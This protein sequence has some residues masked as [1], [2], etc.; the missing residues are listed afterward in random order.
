MGKY[1][2]KTFLEDV[3]NR[4]KDLRGDKANTTYLVSEIDW[5]P[6]CGY[7]KVRSYA[8]SKGSD[9]LMKEIKKDDDRELIN[10]QAFDIP[11]YVKNQVGDHWVQNYIHE[12][13]LKPTN[14]YYANGRLGV[15]FNDDVPTW[16]NK[17][18][19]SEIKFFSEKEVLLL[20]M[21]M[22]VRTTDSKAKYVALNKAEGDFEIK[23]QQIDFLKRTNLDAFLEEKPLFSNKELSF[24]MS[25]EGLYL[26][27][28]YLEKSRL[29]SALFPDINEYKEYI[30]SNGLEKIILDSLG[31][32]DSTTAAEIK[33][34]FYGYRP[35]SALDDWNDKKLTDQEILLKKESFKE[36]NPAHEKIKSEIKLGILDKLQKHLQDDMMKLGGY[37]LGSVFEKSENEIFNHIK[38]HINFSM[39]TNNSF[40][41]KSLKQY[42]DICFNVKKAT[43]SFQFKKNDI[44]EVIKVVES[45]NEIISSLENIEKAPP[46]L[47]NLMSYAILAEMSNQAEYQDLSQFFEKLG[48]DTKQLSK[49]LDISYITDENDPKVHDIESF[50]AD[51]YRLVN[52]DYSLSV[53]NNSDEFQLRNLK[54]GN[55]EVIDK[56]IHLGDLKQFESKFSGF[57]TKRDLFIAAGASGYIMTDEHITK[58]LVF[59][60]NLLSMAKNKELEGGKEFS[61]SLYAGLLAL[62]SEAYNNIKVTCLDGLIGK[63][64]I[65]ID[66]DQKRG[67]LIDAIEFQI[68]KR[69][70]QIEGHLSE[71]AYYSVVHSIDQGMAEDIT[72]EV[73]KMSMAYFS[74]YRFMV[75][76]DPAGADNDYGQVVGCDYYIN[77]R[78]KNP[79]E[80]FEPNLLTTQEWHGIVAKDTRLLEFIP[81]E[82]IQKE[83]FWNNYQDLVG[84][85]SYLNHP[86]NDWLQGGFDKYEVF[87]KM[88]KSLLNN[89]VVYSDLV[90][91]GVAEPRQ[92]QKVTEA[93][94]VPDTIKGVQ[95]S[96]EQ[97][98]RLSQGKGVFIKGMKSDRD[99]KLFSGVAKIN[100]E[101]GE[102][103]FTPPMHK[104]KEVQGEKAQQRDER[105]PNQS[106]PTIVVA[107]P[108]AVKAKGR[109]M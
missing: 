61:P 57:H 83:D 24:K 56:R 70:Q 64:E 8:Y 14:S 28:A 48:I 36:I 55:L 76:Y 6:D 73:A 38:N 22:D 77:D 72:P 10:V 1:N 79:A 68:A 71:K 3:S 33:N 87:N 17:L 32:I 20:E 46:L 85:G 104:K 69:T 95:L 25:Q 27:S 30:Q 96:V 59:L 100:K 45:L 2:G 54:N 98:E 23:E 107:K 7:P 94:V 5:S 106:K 81:D 65:K 44:G 58:E 13:H 89:E 31:K 47:D 66:V 29:L 40:G 18:V 41:L 15:L 92:E 34:H 12:N 67:D 35:Q 108:A 109:R 19:D 74:S 42:E 52:G 4:L 50:V 37:E 105:K 51:E 93:F 99:G 11:H 21:I 43:G 88:P 62:N 26:A 82:I 75:E 86:K 9:N 97:R 103:A 84:K 91:I 90:K 63:T 102:V 78:M 101:T 53:G 39:L 49:Y 60:S 80:Y 16:A